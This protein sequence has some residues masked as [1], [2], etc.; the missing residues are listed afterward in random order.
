MLE[1]LLPVPLYIN[2]KIACRGEFER[3]SRMLIHGFLNKEA[4]MNLKEN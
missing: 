3:I 1:G 4:K 2:S